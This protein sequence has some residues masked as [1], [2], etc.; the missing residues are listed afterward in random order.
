[1][2]PY[3]TVVMD[4]VM[5]I[6]VI[7]I[8]AIQLRKFDTQNDG[9]KYIY[10]FA[11]CFRFVIYITTTKQLKGIQLFVWRVCNESRTDVCAGTVFES[12]GSHEVS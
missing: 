5:V 6:M 7:I 10:F 4:T 2:C 12:E 9:Q 8:V 1:M 3:I 11:F